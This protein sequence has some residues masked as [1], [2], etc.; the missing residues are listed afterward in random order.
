LKEG[1]RRDESFT[2]LIQI[3]EK[4]KGSYQNALKK[5]NRKQFN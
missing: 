5:Q 3:E 2:P 4:N 1:Y